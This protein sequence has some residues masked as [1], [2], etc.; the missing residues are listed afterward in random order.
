MKDF[1]GFIVFFVVFTWAWEK[2]HGPAVV[3]TLLALWLVVRL[4]PLV[5]GLLVD[6]WRMSTDPSSIYR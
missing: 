3:M 6:Y 4:T 2:R 5:Y 1:I